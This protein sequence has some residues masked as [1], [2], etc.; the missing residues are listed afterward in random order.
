MSHA[1]CAPSDRHAAVAVAIST[2]PKRVF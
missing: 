1:P 2:I